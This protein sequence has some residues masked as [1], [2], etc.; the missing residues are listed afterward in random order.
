MV[1][2]KTNIRKYGLVSTYLILTFALLIKY[3]SRYGKGDYSYSEYFINYSTGF[4]RRGLTGELILRSPTFVQ[5]NIFLILSALQ[6]IALAYNFLLLFKIGRILDLSQTQLFFLVFCPSFIGFTSW[7]YSCA[8]KKDSLIFAFLLTFIFRYLKLENKNDP[9]VL[10]KFCFFTLLFLIP[11]MLVHEAVIIIIAPF[12]FIILL[13]AFKLLKYNSW[14][15]LCYKLFIFV[16]LF[17]ILI[18]I[19]FVFL[20]FGGEDYDPELNFKAVEK[21]MPL[22]FG[23][24]QTL[25][26]PEYYAKPIS[27][28]LNNQTTLFTYIFCLLISHLILCWILNLRGYFKYFLYNTHL[29][30]FALVVFSDW[31]RIIQLW[32][33]SLF[34]YYCLN[35]AQMKEDYVSHGKNFNFIRSYRNPQILGLIFFI[36]F[37]VPGSPTP[38]YFTDS[39]ALM[40]FIKFFFNLDDRF[41]S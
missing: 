15:F 29:I 18:N 4:T 12:L 21:F 16:V 11:L 7:S 26:A 24:F 33:L 8:F 9:H 25:H 37:R 13:R 30:V 19:F 10:L 32:T 22:N 38:I 34:C 20:I 2:I 28:K 14:N 36:V 31:D 23:S 41:L 1:R 39:F 5:S 17:S 40:I 3:I 27:A 35:Q 6:V